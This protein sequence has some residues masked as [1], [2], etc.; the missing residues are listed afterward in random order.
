MT[1]QVPQ[2]PAAFSP[3]GGWFWVESQGWVWRERKTRKAGE[4]RRA[5]VVPASAQGENNRRR[6]RA[7]EVGGRRTDSWEEGASGGRSGSR[8]SSLPPSRSPSPPWRPMPGAVSG[9]WPACRRSASPQPKD[10]FPSFSHADEA[11]SRSDYEAHSRSDSPL[12][13]APREVV[14]VKLGDN[15]GTLQYQAADASGTWH[16][17]S[18]PRFF[19]LDN[20]E[21]RA[22]V[23]HAGS[24]V[25]VYRNGVL[26]ARS[27]DALRTIQ[28]F[29]GIG[30]GDL[31]SLE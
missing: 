21:V 23:I 29:F 10:E 12:G 31:A 6:A 19:E 14:Q 30:L 16:T 26:V 28:N 20:V 2:H 15:S 8:G 9:S 24:G 25:R 13:E 22:T 1:A 4:E 18:V 11:H 7:E 5:R 3:G 27:A 17:L